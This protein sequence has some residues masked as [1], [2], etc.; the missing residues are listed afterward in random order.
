MSLD[1]ET[2]SPL[3]PLG[4]QLLSTEKL[5]EELQRPARPPGDAVPAWLF[6]LWL[7]GPFL[8]ADFLFGPV[9]HG[10]SEAM[11]G[12]SSIVKVLVGLLLATCMG[13]IPLQSVILSCYAVLSSETWWF[14]FCVL[15]AQ[16]ASASVAGIAGMVVAF[17]LD[18]LS[19]DDQAIENGIRFLCALPT[20]ALAGQLPFWSMRWFRGWRFARLAAAS[21]PTNEPAV[22]QRLSISHLFVATAVVATCLG[23]IRAAPLKTVDGAWVLW[24]LVGIFS[25][26]AF[27]FSLASLVYVL[28]FTCIRSRLLFWCLALA[29][30]AIIGTSVSALLIYYVWLADWDRVLLELPFNTMMFSTIGLTFIVGFTAGLWLLRLHGWAIERFPARDVR[31]A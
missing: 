5:R 26:L 29:L 12:N 30:P 22:D 14:R 4:L 10:M 9:M 13:M 27:G 24:L 25:V 17:Q 3:T 2:E 20:V 15:L 7:T 23:L 21:V 18:H 19:F 6:L 11:V 28:L 8:V 16:L 31:S 1:P